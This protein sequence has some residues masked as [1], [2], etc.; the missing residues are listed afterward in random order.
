MPTNKT[1][2]IT[3]TV[4]E[5]GHTE[6]GFSAALEAIH[7]LSNNL[8]LPKEMAAELLIRVASSILS[9]FEDGL[10]EFDIIC[11]ESR[12]LDFGV[13]NDCVDPCDECEDVCVD[14]DPSLN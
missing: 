5:D 3:L 6:K 2:E 10:E 14:R 13:F 1:R 4:P 9:E 8:G 7:T 12:E 11:D